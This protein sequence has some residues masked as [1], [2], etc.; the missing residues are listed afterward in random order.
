GGV[1]G[2]FCAINFCAAGKKARKTTKMSGYTRYPK[3]WLRCISLMAS[4]FTFRPS[5]GEY[6]INLSITAFNLLLRRSI[7]VIAAVRLRGWNVSENKLASSRHSWFLV[8]E[9]HQPRGAD[10]FHRFRGGLQVKFVLGL[11]IG[12]LAVPAAIWIYLQTSAVPVATA[13]HPLPF[14]AA[15]VNGPLDRRIAREA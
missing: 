12:L 5:G 13:D 10:A 3:L 9:G 11:V 4:S 8:E 6:A 2:A 14:E 7:I 15:I 1:A